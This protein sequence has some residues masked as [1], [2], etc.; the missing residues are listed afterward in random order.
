MNFLSQCQY[1]QVVHALVV[2]GIHILTHDM[3]A[4]TADSTFLGRK[5]GVHFSLNGG[6]E[7]LAAVYDGELQAYIV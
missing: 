1:I 2:D 6:V 4:Q 7:G 3:Y 5:S